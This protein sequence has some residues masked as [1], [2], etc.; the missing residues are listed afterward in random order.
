MVN[1]VKILCFSA[2]LLSISSCTTYYTP[3][4]VGN[5]MGYMAK[6]MVGDEQHTKNYVTGSFVAA[7]PPDNSINF[8][9]GMLN[10]HRS[11]TFKTFNVAY[12]AFGYLG[13]ADH[14]TPTSTTDPNYLNSF[15]E[16]VSGV[17]VKT[18]IGLHSAS[19]NGNTDFR[20]INWENSINHESGNYATLRKQLHNQH[21]N[22][23]D[24]VSNLTTVWT[25]GLS[26]EIIFRSRR[27]NDT[28][29]AFRLF[30]GFTPG[31]EKSFD[32][33]NDS[34]KDNFVIDSQAF[35]FNYYFQFK[36]FSFTY[37]IGNNINL[38]NKL[39][40]GYSF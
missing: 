29:H 27:N 13:I 31:L 8:R 38:S 26:S 1:N 4:I 33:M 23:Y 6:P 3:A 36:K 12:G 30:F 2:L 24:Y 39:S 37:E 28:K 7:A 18:S 16:N 10:I 40:L 35:A 19:K 15:K 25:T 22:K 11:H 17:G 20:F 14:I 32:N 5:N 21:L 34:G 9:M